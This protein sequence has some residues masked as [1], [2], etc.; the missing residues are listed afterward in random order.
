MAPEDIDSP[1]LPRQC[2]YAPDQRTST[3]G[4]T[5]SRFVEGLR[6]PVLSE[7]CSTTIKLPRWWKLAAALAVFG[8]GVAGVSAYTLISVT[9]PQPLGLASPVPRTPAPTPTQ[10]D[11]LAAICRQPAVPSAPAPADLS[12]LWVVQ[13]GSE[14]G[15]RAHEKFVDLPS[16]NIAVAR[17]SRVSGWLLVADDG[18]AVRIETGCVAVELATLHS[19]DTLPGF[20]TADRDDSV[21]DFLHMRDHPYAVLQ[22]YP[23]TINIGRPSGAPVHVRVS[24][25]LEL[26]GIS[27]PAT[28]NLDARLNADQVAAAGSTTVTVGDYCIEVPQGPSGF[29]SVDPHIT[30]EIS[31]VLLKR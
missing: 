9:R 24:G 21:R 19:I 20:H 3:I 28:F 25:A 12:G 23:V 6:E 27:R 11:Q 15:Y 2:S 26:N 16:P 31:L 13:P 29:V 1:S 7:R 17:T 22:V 30:L 5:F 18:A 4:S 14:V 10:A 8:A